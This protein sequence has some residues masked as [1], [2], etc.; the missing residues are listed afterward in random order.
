MLKLLSDV[1]LKPYLTAKIKV[2]TYKTQLAY[3]ERLLAWAEVE[4]VEKAIAVLT[5]LGSDYPYRRQEIVDKICSYL[6]HTF[7]QDKEVDRQWLP[8]LRFGIRSVASLPRY[9]VNGQPLN[10]DLHQMR[11]QSVNFQGNDSEGQLN[12]TGLNFKDVS[13]WGCVIK[14]VEMPRTNFENADL[15][16]TVFEGCSLEWCNFR[17][18]KLNASFMDAGRPTT[19]R[20]TR[21][22]GN[23]L[24]EAII[25]ACHLHNSDGFDQ[26]L[27]QPAIE[28]GRIRL[29]DI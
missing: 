15:G 6:R 13:I 17:N 21:L 2:L 10:I 1:L 11:I 25:D 18:S 22:W 19:F 26:H 9:D 12:L 4:K 8:I 20:N 29:I 3:A 23:N 14:A 16:G 7:P 24:H 5:E 27:I 28:S